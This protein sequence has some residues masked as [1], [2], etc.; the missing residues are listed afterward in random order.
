MIRALLFSLLPS[1]VKV[2]WLRFRGVDVGPGAR[3][4]FGM[5]L[6]GRIVRIGDH[7]RL[8]PFSAIIAD[9]IE[10]GRH[11]RFH[12]FTLM[13]AGRVTLADYAKIGSLTIVSGR[14][15]FFPRSE[16]RVGVNSYIC[17]LCWIDCGQKVIIGDDVSIGGA[18]HIFTHGSFLPYLEG[19]PFQTGD[20]I[21]GD[22]VYVPWRVF[23]MPGTRIGNDVIIGAKALLRGEY[24]ENSMAVGIPARVIKQPYRTPPDDAERERRLFEIFD[25]FLEV[26]DQLGQQV[27][28][29]ARAPGRF[30]VRWQAGRPEQADLF[31]SADPDEPA[32]DDGPCVRVFLDEHSL[33]ER[34][35]FFNA[36][37]R[38]FRIEPRERAL[39]AMVRRLFSYFGVRGMPM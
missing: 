16:L 29:L 31:Y 17:P 2:A 7:A 12:P 18:T 27:E 10:I 5:I 36:R 6:A 35:S 1:R 26:A 3:I 20:V 14:E 11:V 32:P 23:I 28:V 8:G 13:R 30:H 25:K 15:P 38:R 34:G 19:F 4:G 37:L 21:I 22:R 9:T 33:P 39:G 24:P